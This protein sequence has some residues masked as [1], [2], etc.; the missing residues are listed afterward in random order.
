VLLPQK[1]FGSTQNCATRLRVNG[2]LGEAVVLRLDQR[3]IPDLPTLRS[4]GR[5]WNRR[6]NR[7]GVTI[8]WK[9]NRK[10]ARKKFG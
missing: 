9:F 1:E 6:I 7:A 10:A 2:K 5:A 4:E 8:N 3:R